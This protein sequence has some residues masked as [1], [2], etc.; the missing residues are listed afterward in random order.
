MIIERYRT[1]S[2]EYTTRSPILPCVFIGVDQKL[3][4]QLGEP[5]RSDMQRGTYATG[6]VRQVGHVSG[7]ST[8]ALSRS[9]TGDF[10]SRFYSYAKRPTFTAVRISLCVK[11][12]SSTSV[13]CPHT[14]NILYM[15]V[16]FTQAT[17]QVP[18]SLLS[19]TR[20]HSLESADGS[21]GLT[22]APG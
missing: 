18:S 12:N 20:G 19:S 14:Q 2:R 8:I 1:R 22:Y 4:R 21:L 10:K 13:H 15:G 6:H 17:A 11:L 3:C 9:R 5:P 7:L 16:H